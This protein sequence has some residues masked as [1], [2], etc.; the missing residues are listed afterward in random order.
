M[1]V[2]IGRAGREYIISG[3]SN[4][5]GSGAVV[6]WSPL[7]FTARLPP[8][9]TAFRGRECHCSRASRDRHSSSTPHEGGRLM[10]RSSQGNRAFT[11]TLF[12]SIACLAAAAVTAV[13]D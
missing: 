4:E 3:A 6:A 13:S 2:R 9:Y 12:G 7:L 8:E 5:A 11:L 1:A 10:P